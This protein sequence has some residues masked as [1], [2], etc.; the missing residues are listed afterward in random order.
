VRQIV[1][2]IRMIVYIERLNPRGDL[3]CERTE[4]LDGDLATDACFSWTCWTIVGCRQLMGGAKAR[5]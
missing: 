5:P 1:R 2:V 4:V 3:S